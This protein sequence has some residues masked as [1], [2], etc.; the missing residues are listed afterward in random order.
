VQRSKT[1]L[2]F[3]VPDYSPPGMLADNG[4]MAPEF[5][6]ISETSIISAGNE[7]IDLTDG[8]GLFD[9]LGADNINV[10]FQPLISLYQSQGATAVADYLDLYLC[11]GRMPAAMHARVVQMID[12]L[13]FPTSS[14]LNEYKV[15]SAVQVVANSAQASI[16]K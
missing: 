5:Q 13:T 12:E 16:Q 1:V 9:W 7:I 10:N 8:S 6:I 14:E 11:S 3:F 4:L 15:R 2:N